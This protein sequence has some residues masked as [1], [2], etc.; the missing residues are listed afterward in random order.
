MSTLQLWEVITDKYKPELKTNAVAASDAMIAVDKGDF[1]GYVMAQGGPFVSRKDLLI[2]NDYDTAEMGCEYG[3]FV[4]KLKGFQ[5]VG[6]DAV[7]TRTRKWKIQAKSQALL[8]SEESTSSTEGSEL[9][10]WRGIHL[11]DHL[12]NVMGQ[13]AQ[14]RVDKDHVVK[15]K[16]GYYAENQY[17]PPELVDIRPEEAEVWDGWDTTGSKVDNTV[18]FVP[19]WESWD[20]G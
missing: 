1:A 6:D 14:I 2:R 19:S 4:S 5:V 16:Q 11:D 13:G 3:E 7:N 15:L 8:D 12:V 9:L 18:D 17:H 10:N 20:W